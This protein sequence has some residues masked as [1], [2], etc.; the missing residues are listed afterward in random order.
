MAGAFTDLGSSFK[1]LYPQ[2]VVKP[3]VNDEA[4]FRK[5]LKRAVP[6]RYQ[7]SEG[8]V[9]FLA[10]TG[11]ISAMGQMADGI[12]LPPSMDRTDVRL[13]LKPTNFAF[14]IELGLLTM[15]AAASNKSAFNGGEIERNTNNAISH[16]AWFID[17]TYTGTHGTGRR[18]R[19]ESDGSNTFVA[20]EPE[21]VKLLRKGL[22][23][24]TRTTDGGATVR[25]SMDGQRIT[26]IARSTRTVTYGGTDR[27]LV[28]GDHIHVVTTTSQT[29]S[30]TFANGLR[31]LVDDATYLTTVHGASRSTYP[32]LKANVFSNGGVARN[33]TENLL[34]SSA[35]EIQEISGKGITHIWTGPG[36]F[37]K[38]LE[39]IA[40]DKRIMASVSAPGSRSVGYKENEFK[41]YVPGADAML[42]KSWTIIPGEVYLLNMD[43]FFHYVSKELGPLDLGGVNMFNLSPGSSTYNASLLGYVL[44]QE[45]IGCERF[46]AQGVIRDLRDRQ[47]GTL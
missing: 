13:V 29:L 11:T 27:T 4:P 34:V 33:L 10:E 22:Y 41:L 1:E 18:A 6:S 37:E 31:G 2:E 26:Q 21:G 20:D 7:V 30:S 32:E 44:A 43:H 24:S 5:E 28:A 35:H 14:A 15:T 36:Q 19:V 17:S 38:Y 12:A 25:D 40:P 16:L 39:F 3:M 23:L 42:H 47:A 46:D 8:L 9:T 45:N